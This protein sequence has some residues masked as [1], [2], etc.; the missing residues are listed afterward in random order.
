MVGIATL[1]RPWGISVDP[2][3]HAAVHVVQQGQCWLRLGKESAPVRVGQ[4]DV[5]LVA[6][7]TAH[8]IC[9]PAET[10]TAAFGAV[11]AANRSKADLNNET[12]GT[13]LLCARYSLEGAG[14]HPII[15]L[16][17][18]LIHLSRDQIAASE[19]LRLAMELLRI[20]ARADLVGHDIVAPRLL[21]SVFVY[22]LRA[23]IEYQPLGTGG[24]FGALRDR[25]IAQALRLMHERP[26]E[27]WT[28]ASL[29]DSAVQSRATFARHFTQL[30]GEPPLSYLTRWRMNLA[31]KALRETNQTVGEI[32]RAV[33][34]ESI[35]SFSQAFKRATGQSPGAYRNAP[36]FPE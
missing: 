23:W 11:L 25:G 18:P 1:R 33:G 24:W 30:V 10:P 6:S 9:D 36:Q 12:C 16:L 8:T 14:T 3:R 27:A 13:T 22:L 7:G 21:D 31:A 19:P 20:E 34:Y 26:T 35:P 32:G 4:G 15:R 28:V 29:A 17:P 5:V 2:M